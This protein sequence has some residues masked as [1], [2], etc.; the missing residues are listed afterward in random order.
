MRKSILLIGAASVALCCATAFAMASGGGGGMG[1]M[2]GYGGFGNGGSQSVD[3]YSTALRFIRRQE[4]AN[5]IP[6]LN[7]ALADRPHSADILNYLGLTHRMV[8]DLTGSLAFY[9][10]A[11][12]INPD[13]KG[14]HEYLGELYLMMHDSASADAQLA[15]LTRLCP[16]DCDEKDQLT[17]AIADYHANAH[18]A[19]TATAAPAATSA[20]ATTTNQSALSD[21][22]QRAPDALGRRRHVEMLDADRIHDCA[23]RGRQCADR[24]CFTA[25]FRAHR[26]RLAQDLFVRHVDVRHVV[27]AWHRI[28]TEARSQALA[29]FCVV[30]AVFHHYLAQALH[31]TAMHLAE[32]QHR[33]DDAPK[34]VQHAIGYDIHL[35]GFGVDLHLADVAAIG[36]G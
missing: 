35:A 18:P 32:H 7:N 25:A 11:L 12:S 36:E 4:Y 1:G 34:I 19:A 20:P 28:I 22:P 29:R 10:K 3:N 16:T 33:I 30:D 21:G 14:V 17:K 8:G 9:Q 24:S 2:G 23:H 5:A 6:Y 15:E 26:M 13:H 31:H 27:G